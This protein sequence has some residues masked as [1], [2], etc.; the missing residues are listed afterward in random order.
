MQLNAAG[1]LAAATCNRS[2]AGTDGRVL[3]RN[4]RFRPAVTVWHWLTLKVAGSGKDASE[5]L[6]WSRR[7]GR[8]ANHVIT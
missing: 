7:L 5:V 4:Q 1:L 6:K 8:P 3:V 2:T